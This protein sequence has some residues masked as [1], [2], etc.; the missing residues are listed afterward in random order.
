MDNPRTLRL[1]SQNHSLAFASGNWLPSSRFAP[2]CS[3]WNFDSFS[4][5]DC[6]IKLKQNEFL[7]DLFFS[8]LKPPLP[9]LNLWPVRSNPGSEKWVRLVWK[10]WIE[11]GQQALQITQK[12]HHSCLEA[13]RTFMRHCLLHCSPRL[14]LMLTLWAKLLNE[15]CNTIITFNLWGRNPPKQSPCEMWI[16]FFFAFWKFTILPK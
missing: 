10:P 9:P 13:T 16:K 3:S 2:Y 8:D 6:V 7:T 1:N 11:L 15:Y 12:R 5:T 14:A 4:A